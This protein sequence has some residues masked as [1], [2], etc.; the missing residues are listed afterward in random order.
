MG[1]RVVFFSDLSGKELPEGEKNATILI[2]FP[3]KRRGIHLLE[4]LSDE[5][6][7]WAEKGRKITKDEMDA[8]LG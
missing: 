3:D 5:A 7:A 1:Q 4:V 6:Q 2:G 8:L